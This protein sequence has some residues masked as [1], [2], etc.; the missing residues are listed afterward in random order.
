MDEV[1]NNS[2]LLIGG[3]AIGKS[4][5]AKEIAKKTNMPYISTDA[6]KDKLLDSD[7]SY[8]FEKQLKI[9]EKYGYK[10]EKEFLLPYL[11]ESFKELLDNLKEPSVIDIGALST[12]IVDE[13]LRNKLSNFK[14]VIYLYTENVDEIMNRRNIDKNSEL[15]VIYLETHNNLINEEISTKS[16]NVDNKSIEEIINEITTKKTLV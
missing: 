3:M 12:F 5:I 7:K 11:L 1:Y 4:T 9:R 15:G 13:N 2:I 10:G 6:Y 16:I 8:S 14:H